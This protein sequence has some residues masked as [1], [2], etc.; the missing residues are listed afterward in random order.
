[1]WSEWW[2]WMAAAVVLVIL[3]LFAP[4]Y[5]FLG[6]AAGAVVTGIVVAL[7][8]GLS[9]PQLLLLFAAASLVAWAVMRKVF[10]LRGSAPKVFDHD[11][12]DN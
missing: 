5:V 8:A 6:F 3:E 11:I 1:M 9:L 10:G 2:L 4:G 7:V 12:N